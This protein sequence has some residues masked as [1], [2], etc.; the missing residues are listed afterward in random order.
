MRIEIMPRAAP[1]SPATL[2]TRAW[3]FRSLCMIGEIEKTHHP[4]RV[5]DVTTACGFCQL[6]I[7]IKVSN[8]GSE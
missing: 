6:G 4:R 1:D 5:R 8:P 7:H 3:L 2:F